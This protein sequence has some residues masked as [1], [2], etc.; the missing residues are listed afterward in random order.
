M[1]SLALY[2][3]NVISYCRCCHSCVG[4][5]CA[6][7]VDVAVAMAVVLFAVAVVVAGSV[8]VAVVPFAVADAVVGT[9]VVIGAVVSVVGCWCCRCS[10][11]CY[12]AIRSVLVSF[13]HFAFG[14]W[15]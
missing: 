12:T 8:A 3:A 4:V 2:H 14:Q 1:V 5:G 13:L 15:R 11:C 9:A 10:W 7:A 6:V